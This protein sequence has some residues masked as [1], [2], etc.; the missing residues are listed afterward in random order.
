MVVRLSR[1]DGRV[2]T[3]ANS[4]ASVM[5]VNTERKKRGKEINHEMDG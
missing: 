5:C 3:E 4:D 2:V 1:V